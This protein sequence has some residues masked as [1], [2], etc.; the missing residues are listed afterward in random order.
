ME[1]AA[2]ALPER[3]TFVGGHPIA[4]SARGGL[5]AAR[6]ELFDGRP[7][8]LVQGRAP[9]DAMT[10]LT[11][12]V[13]GLGGRPETVDADTHDRVFAWVSHLPQLAAS[14]LM[15]VVGEGVG[16]EGLA[17]S[18]AGLADTTRLAASE[19]TIWRDIA[20]SNRDNLTQALDALIAML[21]ELRQDPGDGAAL[22]RIFSSA[23][24]WRAR[25]MQDKG[26]G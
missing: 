26:Q 15:H 24:E 5:D 12:F 13:E 19:P 10:K 2:A 9:A 8:M 11:T 14:A 25:L 21:Q 6:A 20:S 23:A 22:N 16:R 3:L 17:W 4:G 7:W 18:G 1:E